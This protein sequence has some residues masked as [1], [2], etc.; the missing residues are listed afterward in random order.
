MRYSV[1]SMLIAAAIAPP[2]LAWSWMAVGYFLIAYV[3]LGAIYVGA[4][5]LILD[6]RS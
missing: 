5:V 6:D 3:F 4:V 1:R 2:L